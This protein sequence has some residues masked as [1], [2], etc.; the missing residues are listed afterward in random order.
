MSVF[1]KS[2]VTVAALLASVSIAAPAQA[3]V[4]FNFGFNAPTD[5]GVTYTGKGVIT[6]ADP[7]VGQLKVLTATGSF[8]DGT[9]TRAITNFGGLVGAD[10]GDAFLFKLAG[11]N[12]YVTNSIAFSDTSDPY[13]GIIFNNRTGTVYG[14][15]TND[16]DIVGGSLTFAAVPEPAT[17]AMM[18]VGFAGIGVAA[19]RKRATLAL[20]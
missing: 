19:R 16:G 10:F 15:L 9:S 17:W 3:V 6:T 20:A 2:I 5:T 11:T 18:L 14:G 4:V 7:S 12:T 13:N 8:F 1:T